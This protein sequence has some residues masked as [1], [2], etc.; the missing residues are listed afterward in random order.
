MIQANP[1]RF[2]MAAFLLL[3]RGSEANDT[4]E[5]NLWPPGGTVIESARPLLCSL[6]G[7][8]ALVSIFSTGERAMPFVKCSVDGCN[9]KLQPVLKPDPRDRETWI[10]R[11]CDV[12]FKPACEKH[13]VEV[14]G[15]IICDRCRAERKAWQPPVEL[16]DLG[17][18]P[19]RRPQ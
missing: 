5:A 11:E 10:Y 3:L 12:C 9:K 19:A 4:V 2:R 7:N 1:I 15:Q 6:A 16:I 18:R 14:D 17:I 8:R 13:S